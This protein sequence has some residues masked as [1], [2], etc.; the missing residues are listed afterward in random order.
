MKVLLVLISIFA[1]IADAG[2]QMVAADSITQERVLIGPVSRSAFQ[3]ST[4]Y[5]ANYNLYNPSGELIR[6]IDSTGAG[7]S[8]AVV[9]G[10]WCSDSYMWVP[11]FL[12]ITDS[13]GLAKHI[14]FIAVPRSRGWRDQL[15]PG[16]AIE[17]V[18]TFIFYRGGRELGRIEEEP[19]GDLGDNVVKILR[20]EK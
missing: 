9:F 8:V 16:L 14:S 7:D 5:H 17:K 1:F 19:K 11:M 2:A 12:R 4:W 10:S 3:D 13:T 15:T 6:K 20:G 18:P